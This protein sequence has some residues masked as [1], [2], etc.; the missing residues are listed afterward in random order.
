M[1]ALTKSSLGEAR[2]LDGYIIPGTRVFL[3][4]LAYNP[5]T[6]T[7]FITS[8]EQGT[9]FRATLD[10]P[11]FE[12]MSSAGANGYTAAMG[13]HLEIGFWRLFVAAGVTGMAYVFSANTGASQGRYTNSLAPKTR[14]TMGPNATSPTLINDVTVVGGNAY[15]SDRYHP[16]LFRLPRT[17]MDAMADDCEGQLEPWLPF[18]STVLRCQSGWGFGSSLNLCVMPMWPQ[19]LYVLSSCTKIAEELEMPG[20]NALD[21][22]PT[23]YTLLPVAT[24]RLERHR[25]CPRRNGAW[26]NRPWSRRP[27]HW[28]Q[29][30]HRRCRNRLTAGSGRA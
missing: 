16:V 15:F 1:S 29:S 22:Q 23:A 27:R 6:G 11:D 28:Q 9:V 30:S 7:L 13:V 25:G 2:P 5:T 3:E 24:L 14:G 8:M 17:T 10:H 4:G 26:C 18:D 12:M 21:S 20:W 19:T